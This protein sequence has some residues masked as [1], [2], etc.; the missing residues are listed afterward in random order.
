[1][2]T[3]VKVGLGLGVLWW[4]SRRTTTDTSVTLDY[5]AEDTPQSSLDSFFFDGHDFSVPSFL[6]NSTQLV[7]SIAGAGTAAVG[8]GIAAHVLPLAAGPI[9]GAIAAGAV[10]VTA[11]V[12]QIG[13]GRKEADRI[14]PTQNKIG[15]LLDQYDHL[16][17]VPRSGPEL[18]ALGDYLQQVYNA[19]LHFTDPASWPDGRAARQ[20]QATINW[21]VEAR[22]QRIRSL[23]SAA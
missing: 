10:L 2:K 22:L 12:S 21:Q 4:L 5:G 14:V 3:A 16:L 23:A 7:G 11:I 1:M 13:R 18:A 15:E 17:A 8:A 20:A 9:G 6:N 19:W